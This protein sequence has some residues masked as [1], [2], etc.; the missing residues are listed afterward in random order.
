MN[1]RRMF[2]A[3]QKMGSLILRLFPAVCA[4]FYINIVVSTSCYNRKLLF[5][6]IL[7]ARIRYNRTHQ[8]ALFPDELPP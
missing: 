7:R 4:P 3:I 2:W 5:P 8:G 6:A 1:A